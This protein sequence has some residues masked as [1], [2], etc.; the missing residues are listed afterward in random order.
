MPTVTIPEVGDVEFPDSMSMDEI[1]AAA[2]RIYNK[3]RGKPDYAAR[4]ARVQA[5]EDIPPGV[6]LET[7]ENPNV[8]KR[9]ARNFSEGNER[10][11]WAA[12]PGVGDPRAS[13]LPRILAA[14]EGLLQELGSP[15]TGATESFER[16]VTKR[17]GLVGPEVEEHARGWGKV[18]QMEAE[19]LFGMAGRY[20]P[21]PKAL[22]KLLEKPETGGI[23]LRTAEP[24]LVEIPET[25]D[26]VE[27]NLPPT[28][29]R[30]ARLRE[31]LVASGINPDD[32]LQLDAALSEAKGVPPATEITV[33]ETPVSK[34]TID[35]DNVRIDL[36]SGEP[37]ELV[38]E[39]LHQ[40]AEAKG[41]EHPPEDNN[42]ILDSETRALNSAYN[43]EARAGQ[44]IVQDNVP[45]PEMEQD[46]E[47]ATGPY[48]ARA[49]AAPERT[50]EP[51]QLL[52][53][54]ELPPPDIKKGTIGPKE[55]AIMSQEPLPEDLDIGTGGEDV[56]RT[57]R[58]RASRLA[59]QKR[60]R[61]AAAGKVSP[62]KRAAA[63]SATDQAEADSI[64]GKF[65]RAFGDVVDF[66]NVMLTSRPRTA[67]RNIRTQAIALM[68]DNI[69]TAIARGVQKAMGAEMMP[70]SV[71]A[72]GRMFTSAREDKQIWDMMVKMNPEAERLLESYMSAER[73]ARFANPTM[74]KM[75]EVVSYANNMQEGW[76]RR[77]VA[78]NYL[79]QVAK[80]KAGVSINE[81]VRNGNFNDVITS[82]DI[83]GSIKQAREVT[84]SLEPENA[85]AEWILKG[86]KFAAVRAVQPFMRFG[87]NS[88]R[89]IYHHSPMIWGE[90]GFKAATK[91]EYLAAMKA[92]D[93]T[94][95]KN[96][97]EGF[98]GTMMLA[99][100][101][102]VGSKIMK[103][104]DSLEALG[105]RINIKP[106]NPMSAYLV[107]G[108]L[109]RRSILK[110]PAPLY[111]GDIRYILSAVLNSSQKAPASEQVNQLMSNI[112]TEG[113]RL[114]IT[115][116]RLREITGQW[117]AR[118]TLL[119]QSINAMLSVADPELAVMRDTSEHWYDPTLANIPY[120]NK[121]LPKR[122]GTDY[123]GPVVVQNPAIGEM[124]GISFE[125]EGSPIFKE[126]ELY[127]V[128]PRYN[129]FP[130]ESKYNNEY[131]KIYGELLEQ[132]GN[133]MVNSPEYK[134][135]P[136]NL[137]RSK[138]ENL[139]TS[140]ALIAK[141]KAMKDMPEDMRREFLL[142][143]STRSLMG[144]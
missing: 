38:H 36:A 60:I 19:N 57:E 123:A 35:G 61:D 73:G 143:R 13:I 103:D 79:D 136:I 47:A 53:T 24:E 81:L 95:I 21:R 90:L 98:T 102:L 10:L 7:P 30:A 69:D 134:H 130:G 110:D 91:P 74:D 43:R 127:Q 122:Y 96:A 85:V 2:K 112:M 75:A 128:K 18:A 129:P 33:G 115:E 37:H 86:R 133:S 78:L 28:P 140:L 9:I 14:T 101:A 139:R 108:F 51:S 52:T 104:V 132:G 99:G 119:G 32:T 131:R 126:M 82:A 121:S 49:T 48:P 67:I 77:G 55:E 120:V 44:P 142:D 107:A 1:R 58:I 27:P 105:N 34:T 94:I 16:G 116:T 66:G 87:Y 39:K 65:K 8:F 20:S 56:A 97:V 45:G 54:R 29:D 72:W 25:G 5:G 41:L 26:I 118:Y 22:P 138:L 76:T 6:D 111:E 117:L 124:T 42:A 100:A 106:E 50:I 114:K 15:L 141:R 64:Y 12:S 93:P 11:K 4:Y 83:A 62:A 125:K 3:K 144:E 59:Q 40:E 84:F 80:K 88:G 71:Q 17:M 31:D 92:G 89:F 135:A 46:F 63:I 109:A 113:G 70:S 23:N 68:L 137:K